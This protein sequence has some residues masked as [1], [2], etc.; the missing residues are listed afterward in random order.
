MCLGG[1]LNPAAFIDIYTPKI[2]LALK[3]YLAKHPSLNYL[4]DDLKSAGVLKLV[5]L[6]QSIEQLSPDDV[7][8]YIYSCIYR[9]MGEATRLE[10]G[11]KHGRHGTPVQKEELKDVHVTPDPFAATETLEVIYACC[12]NA[13]D[14]VIVKFRSEGY[15]DE[16]IAAAVGRSRNRIVERRLEIEER[17]KNYDS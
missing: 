9:A 10:D 13:L 8:G 2:E 14:R 12:F 15:S 6:S 5:E 16:E 4:R 17:Y 11:V 3:S 1:D 7:G